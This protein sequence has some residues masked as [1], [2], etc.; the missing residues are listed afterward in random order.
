MKSLV[1]DLTWNKLCGSSRYTG[2][3]ANLRSPFVQST[4]NRSI[5]C[6]QGNN[7]DDTMPTL[8]WQ[9]PS[10]KVIC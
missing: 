3:L 1:V 8:K 6:I 10:Q 9:P 4:V 5:N 7:F 2:L